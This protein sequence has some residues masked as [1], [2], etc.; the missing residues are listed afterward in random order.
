MLRRE[1]PVLHPQLVERIAKFYDAE[2][3]SDHHPFSQRGQRIAYQHDLPTD[4]RTQLEE[5]SSPQFLSLSHL[6]PQ[7]NRKVY[8]LV[9]DILNEEKPELGLHPIKAP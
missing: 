7:N 6:P 1:K 9:L 3:G 2:Y 5:V 4:L 8:L